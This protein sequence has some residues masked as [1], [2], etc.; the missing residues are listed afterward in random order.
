[1]PADVWVASENHQLLAAAVDSSGAAVI[2]G[3]VMYSA[4]GA[5]LLNRSVLWQPGRGMGATSDTL[6][7]YDKRHLVPFG[8]FV[9]LRSLTQ[10]W[11]E[12][13]ATVSVDFQPGTKPG[14][15][16]T[17]SGVRVGTVLCFETAYD[18]VTADVM[19][20]DV[21]TV[22]TNNG[23]FL[24]TEQPEQQF[25]ISKS[26]AAEAGRPLAVAAATGVSGIIDRTG[27]VLPGTHVADNI[28]SAQVRVVA[29]GGLPSPAR[30]TGPILRWGSVGFMLIA[31]LSWAVTSRRRSDD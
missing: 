30:I 18:D 3:I 8:E 20:A 4:S 6:Q 13:L 24:G 7:V 1:M 21:L 10:A 27:R 28:A 17:D 26:R 2:A 15:F 23:A 31:I 9:P 12:K 19:Q 22:Q 25:Q 11:A 16:H 5:H 29:A 14:L